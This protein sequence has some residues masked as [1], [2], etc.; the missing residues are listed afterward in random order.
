[1][2]RGCGFSLNEKLCVLF[3]ISNYGIRSASQLLCVLKVFVR[4]V[5]LKNIKEDF[6]LVEKMRKFFMKLG[7]L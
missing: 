1:M 2:G 4:P 3:A 5:G 7:I 6:F